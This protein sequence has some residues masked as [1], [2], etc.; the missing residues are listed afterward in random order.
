[1]YH[2][3]FSYLMSETHLKW[4]FYHSKIFLFNLDQFF[5]HQQKQ[6][7]TFSFYLVSLAS[8]KKCSVIFPLLLSSF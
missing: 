4:A 2:F 7:K 3:S 5:K 1:V 6:L 8:P